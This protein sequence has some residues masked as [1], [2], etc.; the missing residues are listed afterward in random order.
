MPGH[1]SAH[2]FCEG[3]LRRASAHPRPGA[4]P[5]IHNMRMFLLITITSPARDK[6][7]FG[8][9]LLRIGILLPLHTP[10]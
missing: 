10:E 4:I 1:Y 6:T 2:P 9:V 8:S 5:T 7:H 3:S